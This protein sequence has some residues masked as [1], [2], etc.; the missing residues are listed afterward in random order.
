MISNSSTIVFKGYD[1]SLRG[2]ILL[3]GAFRGD[4]FIV[5]LKM[6]LRF[7]Y[8]GKMTKNQFKGTRGHKKSV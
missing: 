2:K 7:E 1:E 3:Q 4:D 5:I 8:L 6:F